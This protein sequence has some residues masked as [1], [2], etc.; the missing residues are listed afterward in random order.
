MSDMKN[1]MR[2][3]FRNRE[4]NIEDLLRNGELSDKQVTEIEFRDGQVYVHWEER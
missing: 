4:I 3:S 1:P 2:F